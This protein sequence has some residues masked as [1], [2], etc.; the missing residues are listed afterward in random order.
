MGSPQTLSEADRRIVAVWAADCAERVLG[1]FEA[2]APGDSRAR[3]AIAQTRAFARGELGVAQGIRRRFIGRVAAG[4]VSAHAAVAAERPGRLQASRTWART[5]WVPPRMPPRRLDWQ[6]PTGRRLSVRRS[7][8]SLAA[9][10]QR[11]K[12]PCDSCRPSVRMGRVPSGRCLYRRV[13][14]AHDHP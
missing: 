3:D 1:L 14:W 6:R 5:P 13:F 10:P 4:E 7:A 8:G 11:P 2:E 12:P 9:S